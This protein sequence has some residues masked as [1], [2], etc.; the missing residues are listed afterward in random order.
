MRQFDADALAREI[1]T[2]IPS[3]YFS[4]DSGMLYSDKLREILRRHVPEGPGVV[5]VTAEDLADVAEEAPAW[6]HPHTMHEVRANK[7]NARLRAR[8]AAPDTIACRVVKRP[9]REVS[10]L[11]PMPDEPVLCCFGSREPAFFEEG[12]SVSHPGVTRWCLISDFNASFD[13]TT[14][15]PWRVRTATPEP[16]PWTASD[17]PDGYVFCY[18]AMGG[19]DSFGPYAD[20][21]VIALALNRNECRAILI[22]PAQVTP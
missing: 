17:V 20:R 16:A 10:V 3:W 12:S 13:G 4:T 6:T 15:I 11:P 14:P 22:L 1:A 18:Y 8:A 21:D 19:F 7:L 2:E 9:V 5:E